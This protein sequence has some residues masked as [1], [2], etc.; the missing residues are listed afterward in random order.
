MPELPEVE[1]IVRGLAGQ[2]KGLL[3]KRARVTGHKMFEESA[4][5]FSS[6]LEGRPIS[7][8]NRHGKAIFITLG[9]GP[10]TTVLRIHLGMSGKL[11]WDEQSKPMKK[12]THVLFEIDHPS[13]DLRF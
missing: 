10:T 7:D 8:I 13:H 12:H 11:L 2:I 3:L 1:T 4:D 9:S 6:R 5:E